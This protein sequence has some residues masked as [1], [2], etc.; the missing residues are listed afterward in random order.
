MIFLMGARGFVGSAFARF[1]EKRKVSYVAI[2]RETYESFAGRKC[3]ILINAAGN[4]KKYLAD[5][6]P[7]ADFNQSVLLS[8]R[9]LHDFRPTFYVLLSSVDVYPVL[10]DPAKNHEGIMFDP[11]QSSIYGFH[12]RMAEFLVQK[13]A[14]SWLIVRLAGMVGRGLKKNPVYDVL[15]ERPLYVHPDTQYQFMPTETVAHTVWRLIQN[16][17]T[18]DI[19]NVCG[20]GLIS[21]RQIAALAKKPLNVS[22]LPADAVPRIV[23]VNTKKINKLMPMPQTSK[24]VTTYIEQATLA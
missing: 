4:S 12:K 16:K 2:H 3:D 9:A 17:I 8:L 6:D 19:F 7:L 23:W 14:A 20:Q 18:N 21:P 13:H 22:L 1:F 10:A 15:H 24:T 5:Q 11:L